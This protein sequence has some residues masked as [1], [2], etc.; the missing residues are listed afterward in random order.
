MPNLTNT[1]IYR[2]VV[3]WHFAVKYT[4]NIGISTTYE[5]GSSSEP[6][7]VYE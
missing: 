1:S 5:G 3:A 4:T 2:M 6:K 7:E